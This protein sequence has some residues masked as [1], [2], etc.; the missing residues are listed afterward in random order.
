MRGPKSAAKPFHDTF[1]SSQQK[2][3]I[4]SSGGASAHHL[5]SRIVIALPK[6]GQKNWLRGKSFKDAV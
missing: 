3:A 6:N 1:T 5:I 4:N 2:V